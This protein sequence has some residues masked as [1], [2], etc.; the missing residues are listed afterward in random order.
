MKRVIIMYEN[1]R[2]VNRYAA[3]MI[4]K[5]K[6][7]KLYRRY[8][9][10]RGLKGNSWEDY[11]AHADEDDDLEYWKVWYLSGAR[12]FAS[13]CSNSKLRSMFKNELSYDDY[14]DMTSLHHSQYK[15]YFDYWWTIT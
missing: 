14:D 5:K 7:K 15:K 13:D 11:V 6:L 8:W 2:Q 10:G 4:H 1:G 12:K 3:K 9:W